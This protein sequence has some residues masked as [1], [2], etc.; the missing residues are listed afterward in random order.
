MK[1]DVTYFAEEKVKIDKK[2][3]NIKTSK[4]LALLRVHTVLFA[5]RSAA[6]LYVLLWV[7]THVW[8]WW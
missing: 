8:T 6:L 7:W 2:L 5:F 3:Q 4:C 1:A